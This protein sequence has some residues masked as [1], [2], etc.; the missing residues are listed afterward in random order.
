MQACFRNALI[1]VVLGA[2]AASASIIVD[3]GIP[4]S[5]FTEGVST[6]AT[7][8]ET[9]GVQIFAAGYTGAPGNTAGTLTALYA[10]TAGGDEEGLGLNN[11]SSGDHE[12]TPGNYIQLNLSQLHLYSALTS[13]VLAVDSST[14]SDAYAIYLSATAGVAGTLYQSGTA[15]TSYTLTKAQLTADPY[16]TLTA[17][18]GNVL[19]GP[20]TIVLANPEPVTMATLGTGLLLIGLWRSRKK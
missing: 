16:V 20:G 4:N 17:T 5:G 1:G 2:S 18:A 13:F 15:E 9:A 8:T 12:I 3:F 6:T 14:G 11:D 7:Y 19:L 10:K